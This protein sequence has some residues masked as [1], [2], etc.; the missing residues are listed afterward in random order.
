MRTT[1]PVL[2]VLCIAVAGAM[3]SGSGFADVWGTPEPETAGA[4]S[5]LEERSE[6]VSPAGESG[7]ATGPVSSGESSIV[8]L[9]VDGSQS[10]AGI[11]AAVVLLPVTMTNNGF[12]WWFAYPVGSIAYIISGIGVIEFVTNRVWS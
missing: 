2:M 3:I 12:P 7:S 4:Q 8:G 10:V 11:A 1:A 6:A 5:A 9:V